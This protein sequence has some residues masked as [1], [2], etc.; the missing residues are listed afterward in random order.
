[1]PDLGSNSLQSLSADNESDQGQANGKYYAKC[2]LKIFL[3]RGLPHEKASIPVP[4]DPYGKIEISTI[5][6]L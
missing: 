4:T 6:D 5:I 2:F 3:V 1:M